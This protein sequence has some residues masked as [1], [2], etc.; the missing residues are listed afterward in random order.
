MNEPEALAE[1][2]RHQIV[3]PPSNGDPAQRASSNDAPA[4]PR[5]WSPR[6][7]WG[8]L[9]VAYFD[10]V[11]ENGTPILRVARFE[12]PDPDAKRGREKIFQPFL[13]QPGS[14]FVTEPGSGPL[15]PLYHLDERASALAAGAAVYLVEGPGKADVLR[16]ALRAC[17]DLAWVTTLGSS[18]N[19][20]TDYDLEKFAGFNRANVLADSDE[21][22]RK[23]AK[24]NGD[25]IACGYPAAVVRVGEFYPDADDKEHPDW[26]K[27]VE[28]FFNEGGTLEA[29]RA[30]VERAKRVVEQAPKPE[31]SG[32]GSDDEGWALRSAADVSGEI[33]PV[34][35]DVHGLLERHGGPVLIYG[36]PEALKSWI[37]MHI[38]RCILTGEAVF[39]HFSVTARRDAIYLNFDAPA[40]AFERRV[41]LNK[42]EA[43]LGIARLLFA[44]PEMYDVGRLDAIFTA[45]PGAFVTLDCFADIY[46][47]SPKVEQG[48]AMRAFVRGLRKRY[49]AG[50][51]NGIVIDHARRPTPGASVMTERYYGSIQKKAA[52]RQAWLVER[53]RTA[54]ADP[55]VIRAKIVCEKQGDAEKFEPFAIEARWT[56]T[57]VTLAYVGPFKEEG[58]KT[59]AAMRH[60]ELIEPFLTGNPTGLTAKQ[61]AEKT[62]LSKRQVLD[63]VK[64]PSIAPVGEGPA[65]RY[66]LSAAVEVDDDEDADTES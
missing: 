54:S 11:E 50:G 4:T 39:G 9:L 27:D 61:I 53:L 55:T 24:A 23:S 66:I 13:A 46:S 42:N 65:R 30:I 62:K 64:T 25:L 48:Q 37:A 56:P 8:F 63:A 49:E 33:A 40:R 10:F 52:F 22:G 1:N 29:F 5:Q 26:A 47:P 2:F 7:P 57:S 12:K 51:H 17:N 15:H 20:L 38:S 36:M 3:T 45:H 34:E 28:D 6:I 19:R 32:R 43:P 44:S 59:G 18:S 14:G 35:W 41:A 58:A 31:V 21:S 16:A 60:R